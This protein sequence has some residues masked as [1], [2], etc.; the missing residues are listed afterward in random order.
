MAITKAKSKRTVRDFMTADPF[1]VGPIDTLATARKLMKEHD[2][3][4]LPVVD[5]GSP[6]G[7]VSERDLFAIERYRD[8]VPE[9]TEVHEAMAPLPYCVEAAAP[10]D[11]VIS[12]MAANRLGSA[13]VVEHGKLIGLFTTV[14]ALRATL[15]LC[16]QRNRS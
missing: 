3:R 14:D 11:E 1:T 12:Q 16:R 5:G 9:R 15:E 7:L 6:V 2:I 10:L 13:L 4:H 8:V